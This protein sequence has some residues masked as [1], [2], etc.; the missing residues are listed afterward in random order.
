MAAAG[1]EQNTNIRQAQEGMQAG[2]Q[3]AGI[4]IMENARIPPALQPTIAYL[5]ADERDFGSLPFGDDSDFGLINDMSFPGMLTFAH[6]ITSV[7]AAGK[8]RLELKEVLQSIGRPVR[9]MGRRF[10]NYEGAG[11]YGGEATT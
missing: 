2:S 4:H 3:S 8:G 9:R 6:S 1:G 5:W 11:E 7:A 10:G